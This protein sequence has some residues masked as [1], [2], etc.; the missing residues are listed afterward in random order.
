MGYLPIVFMLIYQTFFFQKNFKK[1]HFLKNYGTIFL[2]VF[3]IINFIY[4][5][6]FVVHNKK[7]VIESKKLNDYVK[8]IITET[9]SKKIVASS[10]YFYKSHLLPL[11]HQYSSDIYF[12]S[13]WRF[14]NLCDDL[15]NYHEHK[16]DFDIIFSGRKFE[17][18]KCDFVEKNFYLKTVDSYGA[19]YVKNPN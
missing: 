18:H 14:K 13:N 16:I 15:M 11:F 5:I 7:S 2:I 1:T 10:S 19:I 4:N 6:L 12:F 9:N 8:S 17:K 3:I